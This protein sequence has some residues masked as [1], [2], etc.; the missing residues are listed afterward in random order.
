MENIKVTRTTYMVEGMNEPC[1]EVSDGYTMVRISK[2]YHYIGKDTLYLAEYL[3]GDFNSNEE[4]DGDFD[5][6]TDNDARRLAKKFSI[7]IS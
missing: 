6:L 4:W 1:I 5:S 7:Y 2:C 3:D